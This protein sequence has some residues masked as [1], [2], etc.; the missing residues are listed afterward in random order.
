MPSI[1]TMLTRA[2]YAFFVPHRRGQGLSGGTYIDQGLTT[3]PN[4]QPVR[5]DP[6]KQKFADDMADGQLEDQY[7]A[8][9]YLDSRDEVDKTRLGVFGQSYGGIQ[10][11]LSMQPRTLATS[12]IQVSFNYRAVVAFA[13]AVWVWF[14]PVRKL[15]TPVV[16]DK[17]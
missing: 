8:L 5:G 11:I 16:T 12:G 1:G 13:P 3:G 9:K 17:T 2:G 4:G 14:D 15:L 10:A 6:E 7:A